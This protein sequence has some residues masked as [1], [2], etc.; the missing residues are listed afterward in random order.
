MSRLHKI[1]S[2]SVEL[3]KYPEF[4]ERGEGR[5]FQPGVDTSRGVANE[6]WQKQILCR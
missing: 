2:T 4:R 3:L 6:V 1:G 5:E